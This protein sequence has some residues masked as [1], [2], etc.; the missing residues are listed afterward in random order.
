MG[1]TFGSLSLGFAFW[2]QSFTADLPTDIL[3]K[4]SLLKNTR[5][6]HAYLGVALLWFAISFCGLIHVAYKRLTR[7]LANKSLQPTRQKRARG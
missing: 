5:P 3:I 7:R 1:L 2:A 6:S 4:G